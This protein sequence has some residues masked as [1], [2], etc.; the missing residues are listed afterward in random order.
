MRTKGAIWLRA[1]RAEGLPF[2][3]RAV[4]ESVCRHFGF[5]SSAHGQDHGP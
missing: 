3:V 1:P 5:Q 2:E 4:G